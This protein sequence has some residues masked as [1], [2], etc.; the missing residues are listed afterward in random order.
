VN[1]HSGSSA[2][3]FQLTPNSHRRDWRCALNKILGVPNTFFV[4]GTAFFRPRDVGHVCARIVVIPGL[5]LCHE[6]CTSVCCLL[7][8]IEGDLSLLLM[9]CLPCLRLL[10]SSLFNQICCNASDKG[11]LVDHFDAVRGC[12][13][14]AL[15]LDSNW[16]QALICFTCSQKF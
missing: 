1:E 7:S 15:L 8:Y 9:V 6:P 14:W 4:S 2:E 10:H 16:I 5:L 3:L 13:T 12:L 11:T